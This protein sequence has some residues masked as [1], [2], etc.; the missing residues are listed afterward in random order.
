MALT[1]KNRN[2]RRRSTP[3]KEG[4]QFKKDNQQEHSFFGETSQEPFF[5]PSNIISTVQSVQRKTG[6]IEKEEKQVHRVPEK[7]EEEK[8]VM[9]KADQKEEE[10]AHRMPEKKEEEKKVMKKEDKKEEEKVHRKEKSAAE[11]SPKGNYASSLQGKGNPLSATA[12]QLFSNKMGYDFS[13][14]RIHTGKEA[15]ESAKELNA[16]AYTVGNDIVFGEGQFDTESAEGQKLLAHELA[17]VVQ[18]GKAKNIKKES[19]VVKESADRKVQRGFLGSVWSGIKSIGSAIGSGIKSAAGSAWD[20]LKSAGAWVWDYVTWM[21]SRM[22]SLLKHI[23]SGIIGT[24]SWLWDGFSG[25]LSHI[26]DGVKRLFS[27]AGQGIEGFFSWIWQGIRGGAQWAYQL[28]QGNFSGF[29]TGIG[30]ALSWMGSGVKGFLSWG[31]R[32]I[33]GLAIW[34]WK[35]IKGIAKW[36]WDGFLG[37]LAW[38]GRLVAKLLDIVGTGELWTFLMNIIKFWCTRTLTSVEEAEAR[39]VFGWS[40]S[41]WQVRIDENSLIA[42]IGAFFDHSPDMGVTT[43]HTI[44]FNGPISAAA[45]NTDMKWLIHELTHVAQ[46]TSVGLQYMGEAIHA[47]KAGGGYDYNETDLAAKNLKDFNREQQA[48]IIKKYYGKVLYGSTLFA[49]DYI[50]MKNQAAKG[51]F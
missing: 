10:K 8:K 50:K 43:A 33:E 26:W 9:K 28:L 4:A 21:P 35:G 34:W 1:F 38:V 46:Y 13:S 6:D 39:K 44:N 27:W 25:A 37:G 23:G 49:T 24:I 31:W 51:S 12:N 48:D 3:T 17:H 16:K 2:Y 32:G 7:K 47:Q 5:K 45:G 18:Q 22:W 11:A 19:G 15:A 30:N 14:V 40:I 20:I 42:K 41:Y 29:W 36:A